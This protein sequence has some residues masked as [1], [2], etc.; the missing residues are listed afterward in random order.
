MSGRLGLLSAI[1]VNA[2]LIIP[3]EV[4]S[5]ALPLNQLIHHVLT[6][7]GVRKSRTLRNSTRLSGPKPTVI[8]TRRARSL[9][10]MEASPRLL[11]HPSANAPSS[12]AGATTRV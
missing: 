3:R 6:A 9:A 11:F 10:S 2:C 8:I 4:L 12:N 5:S 1:A 7:D